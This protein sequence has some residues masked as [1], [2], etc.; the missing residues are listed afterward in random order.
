MRL[1]NLA[2]IA[3]LLLLLAGCS[4]L[5]EEIDETKDWSAS[6]LYNEAKDQ[7]NDGNYETAI[8]YFESLEA[9]YPFGPYAQQAELEVAYAYYKFDEPDSAIAAADRFIKIHPRHPNVDYAYYL[10][11]LAN[12][13]RG[14]SL[15][16]RYLP[17][18]P[19]ERDPGAARHSFQDFGE[20]VRKFPN[21]RYAE[22]ARQ[23]MI[24]LRNNLAMYEVHVAD[25]Y[26][27]RSAYVAAANRAEYVIQHYD[28]T[29][30]IPRALEILVQAYRK[31]DMN[32]LAQDAQRVLQMNFPRGGAARATR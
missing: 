22:D 30:A 14:Q 3:W 9:R 26:L 1:T 28:R 21:S 16:D 23:R 18:D 25:Y 20:L 6:K 17:L 8:K 7:L 5:P 12:F 24:F 13:G 4:L 11:G 29:P 2:S 27:R 32:S 10:R 19:S 15:I 31:M